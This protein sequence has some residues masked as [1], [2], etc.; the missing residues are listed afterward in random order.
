[1]NIQKDESKINQPT[2]PLALAAC[3]VCDI[4]TGTPKK[5][6]QRYLD[7]LVMIQRLISS[8]YA[9]S[10]PLKSEWK[11]NP[12]TREL[13]EI[14]SGGIIYFIH[15]ELKLWCE[16]EGLRPKRLFLEGSSNIIDPQQQ[17]REKVVRYIKKEALIDEMKSLVKDTE[18][19]QTLL[20][21]AS[22][23]KYLQSCKSP[24]GTGWNMPGVIKYL[25]DNTDLLKEE[26]IKRFA[27]KAVEDALKQ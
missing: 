23:Y 17:E 12:F 14:K 7:F 22:K 24:D 2:Y 16:T 11:T 15:D 18:K 27:E 6:D 26:V 25:A 21:N 4:Q 13:Y 10:T 8:G 3:I 9:K 1:M 19:F 5:G 20:G